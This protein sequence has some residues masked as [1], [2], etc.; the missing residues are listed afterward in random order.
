MNMWNTIATQMNNS[1]SHTH[2]SQQRIK[3]TGEIFTPTELVIEMLQHIP[4]HHLAPGKTILDPACGDGQFL[5][6]AKW[7]KILHHNMTPTEAC[8]DLYGIDIMRDNVTTTR[9]RLQGG[10]II[11]GNTI[12][13][14]QPLP[15]QT[16]QEREQLIKILGKT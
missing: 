4:L 12:N 14:H 16:P 9:Q 3:T 15:G 11:H 7:I 2:R 5:E 13:P 6:A 8:H 10:T 1:R